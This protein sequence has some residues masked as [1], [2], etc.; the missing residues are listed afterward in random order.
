MLR[1]VRDLGAHVGRLDLGVYQVEIP[2]PEDPE[3]LPDTPTGRA[4]KVVAVRTPHIRP[5]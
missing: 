3:T 5:T 1:I 4:L 2:V